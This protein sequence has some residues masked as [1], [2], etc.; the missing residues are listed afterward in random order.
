MSL[1]SE[2]KGR[3]VCRIIPF[4]FLNIRATYRLAGDCSR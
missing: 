4:V 3:N 2:A 1:G